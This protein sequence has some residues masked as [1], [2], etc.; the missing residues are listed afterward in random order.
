[1]VQYTCNICNDVAADGTSEGGVNQELWDHFY[2]NHKGTDAV[3]VFAD[4]LTVKTE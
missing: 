3:R 4:F 1:M 2:E